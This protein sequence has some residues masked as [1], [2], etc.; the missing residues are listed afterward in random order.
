MQARPNKPP[1]VDQLRDHIDR[2]H[3]GDKV[4]YPDPSA[5]PLGTDDEAGGHPP[6]GEQVASALRYELRNNHGIAEGRTQRLPHPSGEETGKEPSTNWLTRAACR[7]RSILA[8]VR[9]RS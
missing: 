8:G 9:R 4:A 6:A 2:G 3:T 5:A 7:L 1:T